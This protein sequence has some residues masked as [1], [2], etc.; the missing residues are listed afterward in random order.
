MTK[1][2]IGQL[3]RARVFNAAI[4]TK[5]ETNKTFYPA[6]LYHQDFLTKHPT[7][8][9]IVHNDLPKIEDLKRIFADVYRYEPVLVVSSRPSG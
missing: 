7:H 3:N 1:A 8:P 6:E 9:Y 2:Y 4:V 5:I